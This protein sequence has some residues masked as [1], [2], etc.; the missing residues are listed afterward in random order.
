MTGFLKEY[1]DLTKHFSEKKKIFHKLGLKSFKLLKIPIR[2]NVIEIAV[3]RLCQKSSYVT[4]EFT[5][6]SSD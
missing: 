4:W 5:P 2:Q 6:K 1:L 3:T